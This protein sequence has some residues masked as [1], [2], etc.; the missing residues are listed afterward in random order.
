MAEVETATFALHLSSEARNAHEKLAHS[1]TLE[2]IRD[3]V[4]LSAKVVFAG[5]ALRIAIA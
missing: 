2:R 5:G 3:H 4:A 1:G